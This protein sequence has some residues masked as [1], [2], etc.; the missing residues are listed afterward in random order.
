[1]FLVE[2][3]FSLAEMN[4]FLD[5]FLRLF[6]FS[7]KILF[8]REMFPIFS[9]FEFSCTSFSFSFSRFAFSEI[10]FF[11]EASMMSLTCSTYCF[12]FS[13]LGLAPRPGA[14]TSGGRC[15]CRS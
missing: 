13:I 11:R 5:L 6:I 2:L 8:S 9:I 15:S 3:C 14:L 12:H 7:R 10:R 1:M 4:R